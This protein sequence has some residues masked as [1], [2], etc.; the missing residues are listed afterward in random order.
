VSPR[1]QYLP[2]VTVFNSSIA[3]IGAK[4]FPGQSAEHALPGAALNVVD[5]ACGSGPK[6]SALPEV[7]SMN[8]EVAVCENVMAA[9]ALSPPGLTL[10]SNHESHLRVIPAPNAI[11]DVGTV[12][13]FQRRRDRRRS[14]SGRKICFHRA[15]RR[16]FARSGHRRRYDLT[17]LRVILAATRW[18]RG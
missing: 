12:A 14:Q 5:F 1:D 15:N 7:K 4:L 2:F 11:T 18:R 8:T 9:G 3:A 17:S 13:L 6:Q 16:L 10:L